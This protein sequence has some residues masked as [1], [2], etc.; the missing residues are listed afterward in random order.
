MGYSMKAAMDN[1]YTNACGYVPI[2]LHLWTP[3]FEFCIIF[4]YYEVMFFLK[5]FQGLTK[6]KIIL[7]SYKICSRLDSALWTTACQPL[8]RLIHWFRGSRTG[9]RFSI[10]NRIFLVAPSSSVL[11]S[12]QAW[13]WI[14]THLKHFRTQFLL[15]GQ[16]MKMLHVVNGF[17]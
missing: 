4:T 11:Y 15:L 6:V 13:K 8:G 1:M 14:V 10:Y 16:T 2:K 5:F 3:K 7:S 12:W 17:Q 9:F